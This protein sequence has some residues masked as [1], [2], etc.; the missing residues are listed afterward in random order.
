MPEWLQF[1]L[2]LYLLCFG[3]IGLVFCVV[4]VIAVARALLE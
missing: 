3:G 1:I 2:F 4:L